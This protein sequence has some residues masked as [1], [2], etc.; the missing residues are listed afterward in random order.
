MVSRG[1]GPAAR[2]AGYRHSLLIATMATS[3]RARHRGSIEAPS[4]PR[5]RRYPAAPSL[6]QGRRGGGL[7]GARCFGSIAAAHQEPHGHRFDE[8]ALDLAAGGMDEPERTCLIDQSLSLTIPTIDWR[9][10]LLET[11]GPRNEPVQPFV[12][13]PEEDVLVPRRRW[14]IA[15]DHAPPVRVSPVVDPGPAEMASISQTIAKPPHRREN[16]MRYQ[17][18]RML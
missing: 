17:A 11:R 8:E 12:V 15:T 2:Y 6:D 5:L 9:H 16:G 10:R 18:P 14:H 13:G 3:R 4:F 7:T 1:S